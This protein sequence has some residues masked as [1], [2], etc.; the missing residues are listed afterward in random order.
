MPGIGGSI[1]E[2]SIDGRTY[3][4]AADSDATLALGGDTNEVQANGDGSAR[5]LKTVTPWGVTGLNVVNNHDERSHE[6]LQ[7]VADRNEF[8]ACTI[9]LASGTVYM[10]DGQ[11]ADTIEGSSAS[12]TIGV[13]LM[14]QGKLEQQ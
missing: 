1:Q 12:A 9:T 14:G 5:L 4:V 8:V 2:I 10:G 7:A 6:A 3:A 11:V 13:G